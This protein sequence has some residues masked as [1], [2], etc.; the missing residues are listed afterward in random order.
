VELV[1]ELGV[2]RA[3]NRVNRKSLEVAPEVVKKEV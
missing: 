1:L 3:M 2:E